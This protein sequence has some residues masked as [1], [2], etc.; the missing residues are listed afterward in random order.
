MSKS[1]QMDANTGYFRVWRLTRDGLV[2]DL[3]GWTGLKASFAL[4]PGAAAA[5]TLSQVTTV[6]QGLR[7]MVPL[8]EGQVDVRIDAATLTGIP[9]TTGSFALYGDLIGVDASGTPRTIDRIIATVQRGV[10]VP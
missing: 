4:E 8:T 6:T 9:D 3:T 5:F 7:P 10:T 2:V 1:I